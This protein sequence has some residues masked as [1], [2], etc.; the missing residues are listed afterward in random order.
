MDDA[1]QPAN[2]T[3][4]ADS[5]AAAASVYDDLIISIQ[6]VAAKSQD[7]DDIGQCLPVRRSS[8]FFSYSRPRRIRIN[9]MP[10]TLHCDYYIV[11]LGF[12]DQV[13][14]RQMGGSVA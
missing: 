4:A 12:P 13:H 1:G 3:P 6:R 14:C 8:D 10:L 7:W 2:I 5:A 11:R 9:K